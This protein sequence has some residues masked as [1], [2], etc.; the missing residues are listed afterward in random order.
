MGLMIVKRDEF[1]YN[2]TY[3]FNPDRNAIELYFPG[4]GF[5]FS[6]LNEDFP[7][8]VYLY[9]ES[10]LGWTDSMCESFK[11]LLFSNDWPEKCVMEMNGII[12]HA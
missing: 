7:E 5:R 3:G 12:Q 9:L 11:N 6:K 1:A 10:D 8:T 4:K 2:V